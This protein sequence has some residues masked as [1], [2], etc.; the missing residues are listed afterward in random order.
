MPVHRGP[1]KWLITSEWESAEP[2]LAWVDS[3]SHRE[4][5]R[6]CTAA[7]RTPARCASPSC[8]R[9]PR[10]VRRSPAPGQGPV[11]DHAADRRRAGAARADVHRAARQRGAGRRDPRRL[12]AA[13]GRV[14]DATRLCR[15]SLFMR[16]NRVVRA[17]EIQGD[18]VAALRHVARQPEVRAVEEAINPYLEVARDLDDPESA[19]EFFQRAA[20][21]AVHHLGAAADRAE[22]GRAAGSDGAGPATTRHALIYRCGAA[23]GPPWPGCWRARTNW[24]PS[25]RRRPWCAPPSSSTTTP[26]CG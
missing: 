9:R 23:A 3:A 26:W 16:G 8:A 2:F 20:L 14:D 6:P 11:A 12:R 5:V 21:P 10:P 1:S 15:T 25:G 19:R 24:P 4:M 22:A 17:V 18:L 7:W 13:G